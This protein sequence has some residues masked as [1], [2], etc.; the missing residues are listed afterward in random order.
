MKNMA[1]DLRGAGKLTTE[2]IVGITHIVEA[3]HAR[4][5]GTVFLQG[6][7]RRERTSGIA[8]LVYW[9]IR[10]ITRLI[11]MGIDVSLG[12]LS[13]MLQHSDSSEGREAVLSA[14]NGV[15]GDYLQTHHNPLAISMTFRQQG[16]ALDKQAIRASL[17]QTEGR[18]LVL[19]HGLCMNDL[20]WAYK[21]HHH[22]NEL[23]RSLGM[24][25]VLLHYNTGRHISQNGKEFAGR[26]ESLLSDFPEIRELHLL[27]HS[28]GGLVS[29]SAFHY[30]G[31]AGQRWT[32][33]VRN[34][35]FLGTPHAGAPLER[36]GNQID[37]ILEIHPYSAPFARLGKIRSAGITDLRHGFLTDEDWEGTDRFDAPT[38]PLTPVPLPTQVRCYAV[39]GLM[40]SAKVPAA[41]SDVAGDGLV[42]LAS[43]LGQHK[44][45]A[46]VIKFEDESQ[47]VIQ[48]LNHL[49]MLSNRQVY[50][51]L[52]TWL[53]TK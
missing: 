12:R 9:L 21:G 19:V 3:M 42:P 51:Q 28:M 2:A 7:T 14:L 43:A 17:L 11:G 8:R 15:L 49:D 32:G 50:D 5:S 39:A 4:I 22:G 37:K 16:K 36:A 40:G 34:L 23:A 35:V 10:T 41:L 45:P 24:T 1:D 27:T 48:N 52:L 25:M 20:Q 44:D 18:M 53:G 33:L 30:G 31:L 6:V 46:R 38:R 13:T 29:R 47:L 26:L